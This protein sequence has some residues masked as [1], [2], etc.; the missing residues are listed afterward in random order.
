MPKSLYRVRCP[1]RAEVLPLIRPRSAPP[2]IHDSET[3]MSR[4]PLSLARSLCISSRASARFAAALLVVAASSISLPA[5]CPSVWNA[6][7]FVAGCPTQV[8][9]NALAQFDD[10]TGPAL[11][12]GVSQSGS[13]IMRWDG[14]KW[15][16][17]GGGTNGSVKALVVFDDGHG[18]ALYVGGSFTMAGT[19]PT[20]SGIARWDGNAWSAL[21]AGAPS[22]TCLAVW[23]DGTGPAIYAAGSF[24]VATGAAGNSI[25]KFNGTSWSSLGSGLTG[26]T[27][28]LRIGRH[29]HDGVQR[30]SGP[31][32]LRR[33]LFHH[34][35][36]D[37]G[38]WNRALEWN[39]VVGP[40]QR[41]RGPNP[42]ERGSVRLLSTIR[43]PDSRSMRAAGFTSAGGVAANRIATVERDVMV[44]ARC[45][46]QRQGDRPVSP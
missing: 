5:Q 15:T 3:V 7:E 21:P 33:R 37:R 36:S 12:A 43:E 17:V 9:I 13:S 27:Q 14:A 32:P 4:K 25:A 34:G 16:D 45:G 41:S 1:E 20:P 38:E 42:H 6:P 40:G 8:G 39:V 10:G 19:T 22:P 46:C 11:Y 23:D 24:T 28:P 2:Q 18:P 29:V 44:G 26:S 31:R 30:L 35:R